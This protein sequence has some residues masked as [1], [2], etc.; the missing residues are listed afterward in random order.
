MCGENLHPLKNFTQAYNVLSSCFR[1]IKN[2]LAL[3][4]HSHGQAAFLQPFLVVKKQQ[5]QPSALIYFHV[6]NGSVTG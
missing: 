2:K 1:R 3:S 6:L 4:R 5:Q